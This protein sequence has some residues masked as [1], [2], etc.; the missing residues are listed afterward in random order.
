MSKF[1]K[2]S[3]MFLKYISIF[4]AISLAGTACVNSPIPQNSKEF[5]INKLEGAPLPS[6]SVIDSKNSIIFGE[7]ALWTGRVELTTP[8]KQED[9]VKFFNTEYPSAGWTLLSSSKSKSS[10]LIFAGKNKTLTLEI[11]ERSGLSSGC[12]ITL[13]VAPMNK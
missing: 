7:G 9:A 12:Q 11:N 2:E 5:S 8:L 13:T 3:I 4:L 6:G 1:K 10:T